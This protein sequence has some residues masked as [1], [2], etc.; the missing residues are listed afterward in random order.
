[1]YR[2]STFN[3]GFNFI[4]NSEPYVSMEDKEQVVA[5]SR[6]GP[7]TAIYGTSQAARC[8]SDVYQNAS[9]ASGFSS[10]DKYS[11]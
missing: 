8:S 9:K 2:V 6:C 1:M 3:P 11:V 4:L 7:T 10:K 5:Q